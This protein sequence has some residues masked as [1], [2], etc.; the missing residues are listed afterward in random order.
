MRSLFQLRFS[1]RAMWIATT[2]IAIYIALVLPP[3]L[4]N[5]FAIDVL[6]F[7]HRASIFPDG[8]HGPLW[9]RA[10]LPGRYTMGLESLSYKSAAIDDSDIPE[11]VRAVRSLPTPLRRMV[12]CDTNVTATG[13][14][15]LRS[16]LPNCEITEC[17]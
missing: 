6:V 9:M 15:S 4:K 11:I 3:R 13:F 5:K 2:I 10:V 14:K 16:E 12:F 17:R 8:F 7:K 1:K